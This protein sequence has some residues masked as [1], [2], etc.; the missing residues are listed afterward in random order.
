VTWASPPRGRPRRSATADITEG[1]SLS[2][3]LRGLARQRLEAAERERRLESVE[4]LREFWEVCDAASSGRERAV[5]RVTTY[6]AAARLL[7]SRV[8]DVWPVEAAAAHLARDLCDKHPGL[9]A[10]D[11]LHLACCLRRGV[12]RIRSFD[13]GLAACFPRAD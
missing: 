2:A 12:S 1:L 13:R 8:G 10:R 11:L 9:G 6:D 5:G 3:W 4:D 7:R